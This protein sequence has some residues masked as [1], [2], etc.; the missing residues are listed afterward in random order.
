MVFPVVVVVLPQ[1]Q[2]QVNFFKI[3]DYLRGFF[4]VPKPVFPKSCDDFPNVTEDLKCSIL[5]DSDDSSALILL[6]APVFV[7]KI[8]YRQQDLSSFH[9]SMSYNVDQFSIFNTA[10]K[11]SLRG[12]FPDKRLSVAQ[13]TNHPGFSAR[14]YEHFFKK[15]PK[16]C[17]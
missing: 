2:K 4:S 5:T 8:G 9:V 16:Y 15:C 6:L 3:P 7:F 10:K 1:L 14:F 17:E 11:T 12:L 13:F